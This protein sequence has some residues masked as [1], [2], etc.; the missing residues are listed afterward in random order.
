MN[1]RKRVIIGTAGHIDHG[2]TMLV[3]ALTGIDT[4]RLKEEKERGITIDIG[5]ADLMVDHMQ[6]AFI[7]V[8]GHERFV[9]N[10]LAGVHGVDLVMLV[11]A[12]DESIMPQTR[13]HFDICRLLEVQ[14]GLVAITKIDLV[15]DELV[16]LVEE[17]V[18]EYVRGS[19]LEG[20]PIV[21][22]SSRTGAG[23][24]QLKAALVQ[25]ADLIHTKK[26][27]ALP[28]LPVDRVFS[29][30]GFGTII[31]GT[32]TSGI[33]REGQTVDILPSRRRA[34]IRGLQVHRG[35]VQ[36]AQAGER[37]AA[38]L[39]AVSVDQVTRG[40]V[41]VPAGRFEPTS[42]IDA[43][44]DL[45]PTAPRPLRT[46]TRVRLHLGTAEILARVVLLDAHVLMPG[47]TGFVQFRLESPT[48][49]VPDDRF[50]IRQYSPCLTI[51]G[52]CVVDG[53]ATKHPP[54]HPE[55]ARSQALIQSLR[56]LTSGCQMERIQVWVE[57]AGRRGI[58]YESLAARSGLTDALLTEALSS[59]VQAQHLI[60]VV[61]QTRYYIATAVYDQLRSALQQM[62][63]EYHQAHPLSEGM[64]REEVRSRLISGQRDEFSVALFGRLLQEPVFD[65]ER[66]V[67]RLR[68][69]QV[70]LSPQ[71]AQQREQL[72]TAIQQA[73][74]QALTLDEVAQR[75]GVNPTVARQLLQPALNQGRLIRLGD[76]LFDADVINHLKATI[77]A[78]KAISNKLDVAAFKQITGVS[79]KYAIPLLE[80]LDRQGVTRRIG[81]ERVI[82]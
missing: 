18:R 69:H 11:V 33:L 42:L 38:N 41:I 57:S 2:K 37:V 27:D 46:R 78:H 80:Y 22:V 25:Q 10:M 40:D 68:T 79:R 36:T 61:G 24:D 15:E 28:R 45:L 50:I 60:E 49:A 82:L 77:R 52:G 6:L 51:G 59:L 12:A 31:T 53:L 62:L 8:P 9:K 13:E 47:Q 16:D 63:A 34:T 65:A 35:S 3:K 23:L 67:V 56:R 21:R 1:E 55:H 20:A 19:F 81:Q 66:D 73:G 54:F 58:S 76:L 72:L 74:Y 39:S 32:L 44:L 48:F 5:F 64:P 14:R 4:D 70:S 43:R 26:T 17:E 7:D 75:T 29:I 71:E 30:K